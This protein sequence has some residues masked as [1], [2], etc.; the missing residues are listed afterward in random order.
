MNLAT[1]RARV[2][3]AIGVDNTDGSAEQALVDGWVNESIVQ[4]LSRTKAHAR[5]AALALTADEG[6]Y[7]LDTDILAMRAAWIEPA[8]GLQEIPLRET[9]PEEIVAYRRYQGV[10]GDPSARLFALQGSNLLHLF[11]APSSSDDVLHIYYIP[12]PA[13]LAASGDSPAATANGGIPEEFHPVLENY[14]KWKAAEYANNG[15]SQLGQMWKAEWEAGLVQVRVANAKKGGLNTQ[16]VRIGAPAR[17][18]SSPGVDNG[19]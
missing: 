17:W 7:T 6:D 12:R 19:A 15:P 5:L 10:S 13:A 18:P 14:V 1:F 2:S 9:S 4:F 3:G 16:R 8:N 11:P